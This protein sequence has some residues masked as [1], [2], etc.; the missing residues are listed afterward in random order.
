M[1]HSNIVH[2]SAPNISPWGR[3][4]AYLSLCHVDNHI[5]QFKR[6]EWIAHRDF[7]PIEPIDD[8]CLRELAREGTAA[9]E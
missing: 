6:E 5:T 9:A 2:A 4:I 7:T 3:A 1:F 8:D